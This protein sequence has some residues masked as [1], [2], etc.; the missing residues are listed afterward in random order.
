[1]TEEQ[2]KRAKEI[3]FDIQALKSQKIVCGLSDSTTESYRTW[4]E[5]TLTKLEEEFKKL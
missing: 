4:L 2:F 1:M 3:Q 5:S